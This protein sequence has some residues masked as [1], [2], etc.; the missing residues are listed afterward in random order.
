MS[1]EEYRQGRLYN[2]INM[3]SGYRLSPVWNTGFLN[4]PPYPEFATLTLAMTGVYGDW[5][6]DQVWNDKGELSA[7][8]SES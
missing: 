2:Y 6:P 4:A 7:I 3:G 8:S 1:G 5:I